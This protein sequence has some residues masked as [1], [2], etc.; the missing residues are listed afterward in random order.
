MMMMTVVVMATAVPGAQASSLR[1]CARALLRQLA[2]APPR[3]RPALRLALLPRLL[4]A[5]VAQTIVLLQFNH[6]V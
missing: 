1:R 4:G 5:V 6:V 3:A 2:A